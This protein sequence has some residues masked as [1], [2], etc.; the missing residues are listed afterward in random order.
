MAGVEKPLMD[1]EVFET[2][3][4]GTDALDA[5]QVPYV[6]GGGIAVWAYG[7]RRWTKDIDVFVTPDDAE[8]ALTALEAGGFRTEKT[9]PAWIYKAFKRH[10]MIDIIFKSKGEIYLDAEALRR[11]EDRVVDDIRFICMAPEDLII[12]KI[13]SMIEERPDWY[14]G[15]SVIDGV[16][17]QLDWKYFA[18]RAEKDPGRVLSFLLYAESEY[19][20]ERVLIPKWIIKDLAKQ[21][22]SRPSLYSA[23]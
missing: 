2:F 20:R 23:A 12:R 6:V 8:K 7:R 3:K 22:I 11:G 16:D 14:D 1:T 19:P 13:F 10:E 5:H 21:V 9:D 15:I 4:E 18:K 17:G